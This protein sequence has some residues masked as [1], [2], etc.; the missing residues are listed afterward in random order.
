[1]SPNETKSAVAS[2]VLRLVAVWLALGVLDLAASGARWLVVAGTEP[3]DG[4]GAFGFLVRWVGTPGGDLWFAYFIAIALVALLLEGAA[5]VWAL[6]PSS[7]ASP[8]LF[9]GLGIAGIAARALS[10]GAS[11]AMTMALSRT[12]HVEALATYGAATSVVGTLH[13]LA[14]W[15]FGAVVLVVLV[16]R[17]LRASSAKSISG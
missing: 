1:M 8:W 15:T 11:F 7:A 13:A 6:R 14:E 4:T 9:L 12:E 16:V 5:L 17:A 3:G 2:A 10:F